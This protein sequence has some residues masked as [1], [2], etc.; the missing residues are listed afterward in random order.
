MRSEIWAPILRDE[1]SEAQI[2]NAIREY[3]HLRKVPHTV[4]D[5]SVYPEPDGKRRR[6]KVDPDWPDISGTLPPEILA[7]GRSL[8]IEVKSKKGRLNRPR[9][10]KLK[11]RTVWT[12]GQKAVLEELREAGAVAFVA[13]SVTEV[14]EVFQNIKRAEAEGVRLEDVLPPLK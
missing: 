14:E 5:A 1:A 3:L 7:G 10:V 9:M 12:R 8:Y 13:R 11:R 2:Q 4:S 6:A